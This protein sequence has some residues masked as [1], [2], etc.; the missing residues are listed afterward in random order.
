LSSGRH[1]GAEDAILEQW[2]SSWSNGIPPHLPIA[3]ALHLIFN[4]IEN[5]FAEFSVELIDLFFVDR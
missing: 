5:N 2:R 3:F 4:Y 1:P